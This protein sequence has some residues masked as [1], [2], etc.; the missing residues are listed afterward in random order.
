[1]Q[2]ISAIS[3]V[4]N[5]GMLYKPRIVK[6]IQG[7]SRHPLVLSHPGPQQVTDA[8]TAATVRGMMETVVLSGTGKLGTAKWIHGSGEVWHR[9][10]IDPNTGRYSPNKYIVSFVGFAPVNEPAMTILIAVRFAGRSA[11]RRRNRGPWTAHR[12]AG[13][14]RTSMWTT[15]F[16]AVPP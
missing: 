3:A 5:G 1:M 9:A 6:E 7:A 10:T 4:E 15:T 12:G 8:T 14:W 2:I 11:P 13:C 16:R